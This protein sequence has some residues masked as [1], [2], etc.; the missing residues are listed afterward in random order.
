MNV[1]A[2]LERAPVRFM[3]KIHENTSG[4]WDWLGHITE[5]GYGQF[6]YEGRFF[7]SHRIALLFFRGID[8]PIGSAILQV[9]HLC[10]NRKCVNPDHLEVVTPRM[11][12]SRSESIS[13]KNGDKTHCLHGHELSNE[14]VYSYHG[15]RVCRK[16]MSEN[17]K[18]YKRRKAYEK[19]RNRSD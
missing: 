10:R 5:N 15:K 7:R 13:R 19:S 17:D 4:C 16:C 1:Q 18:R 8:L 11:N 9:D 12:N 2:R 3:N 6:W 14:N